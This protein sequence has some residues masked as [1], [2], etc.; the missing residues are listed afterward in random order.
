M[1]TIKSYDEFKKSITSIKLRRKPDTGKRY[2]TVFIEF[3]VLSHIKY[4]IYNCI[5]KLNSDWSHTIVCGPENYDYIKKIVGNSKI[6]IIS[7]KVHINNVNDYNNLLLSVS[8]WDLFSG[9]KL[10]VY[11]EDTFLFHGN[12][13]PFLE[14]DYIGAPWV[15]DHVP[16]GYG[17]NGGLSL[18]TKNIMKECLL[19]YPPPPDNSF[20]HF[21]R[22][23]EDLY[24]SS[25]ISSFSIG[26]VAHRKVAVSFSQEQ[27][28]PCVL[29]MGGHK[30]WEARDYYSFMNLEYKIPAEETCLKKTKIPRHFVQTFRDDIHVHKAIVD[31]IHNVLKNNKGFDYRLFTDTI[32]IEYIKEH[33]D[34]HTLDAFKKLK[35]GAAKGDFIR[36]II[37]YLQGGMYLDM[38][39]CINSDMSEY[40]N[41]DFM[42]LYDGNYNIAQWT[43]MMSPKC[44]VMKYIIE[45]MVNRIHKGEQNIFLATGPELVTDVIFGLMTNQK[46]YKN[47]LSRE[48][49]KATLEDNIHFMG[50][51][52]IHEFTKDMRQ[53]FPGYTKEMLYDQANPR[54]TPIVNGGKTPELYN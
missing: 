41:Y 53:Q 54:Y 47:T 2:E 46:L 39:A 35:T 32:G 9:D 19:K 49:K 38:D 23:A 12:I 30:F 4:V 6:R 13:S 34:E 31:N 42:F 36:Y 52:F 8:F 24:F 10:L 33:F 11:Q 27:L 16:G 7:L 22:Q 28:I 21:D 1:N 18:R 17:G 40:L 25:T 48:C 3:R 43:F 14:Y 45:E 37:M 26:K 20:T 5:N 29:P 15:K 51:C 44:V 50:G